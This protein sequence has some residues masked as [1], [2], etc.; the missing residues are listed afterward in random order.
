MAKKLKRKKQ[1]GGFTFKKG[2]INQPY[3]EQAKLTYEARV[4]G[5]DEPL[6]TEDYDIDQRDL[7]KIGRKGDLFLDTTVKK[8]EK[9]KKQVDPMTG[10]KVNKGYSFGPHFPPG[11]EGRR[12]A[13][14]SARKMN[15]AFYVHDGKEYNTLTRIEADKGVKAGSKQHLANMRSGKDYVDWSSKKKK[16][17]RLNKKKKQSGGFLEPPTEK[18]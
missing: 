14:Q 1:G 3:D 13:H 6:I 7:K 2:K 10:K 16:S 4:R 11:F 8:L 18:I 5:H 17:F 12:Q 9:R 15:R